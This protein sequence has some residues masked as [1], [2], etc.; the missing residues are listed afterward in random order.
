MPSKGLHI[1]KAKTLAARL[2]TL[3]C[4]SPNSSAA[5]VALRNLAAVT[6]EGT[7]SELISIITAVRDMRY[8]HV[9]GFEVTLDE[10]AVLPEDPR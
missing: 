3:G 8:T 9:T 7:S 5:R 10:E 2:L 1:H 6:Q 4:V